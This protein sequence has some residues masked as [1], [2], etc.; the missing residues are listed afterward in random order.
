MNESAIAKLVK[1]CMF[2]TNFGQIIFSFAL[3]V[4][5]FNI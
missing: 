2:E 4:S 3:F 5:R 1:S